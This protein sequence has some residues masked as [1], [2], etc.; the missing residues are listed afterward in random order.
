MPYIQKFDEYK[1]PTKAR[2]IQMNEK[3]LEYCKQEI[4]TL[5]NKKLIRPSKSPWSCAVFYVQNVAELK[6]GASRLVIN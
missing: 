6:R 1:T 2:P 5:I 3:L 4:D